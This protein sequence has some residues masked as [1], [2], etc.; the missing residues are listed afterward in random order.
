M[1]KKT[2]KCYST[3]RLVVIVNVALWI[4]G[5]V[6]TC[7]V[8]G[9]AANVAGII[10]V[11]VPLLKVAGTT[12]PPTVTTDEDVKVAFVGVITTWVRTGPLIGSSAIL[13]FFMQ[14]FRL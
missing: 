6:V 9:P 2:R 1:N 10:I 12:T 5:P 3:T 8:T 14:G 13:A 7:T 4:H 11:R